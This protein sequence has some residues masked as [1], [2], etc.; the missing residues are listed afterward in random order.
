MKQNLSILE[1][2]DIYF[3]Y[4][5]RVQTKKAHRPD[6]IQRLYFILKGKQSPH[7]RLII[8]GKKQLP[9]YDE[10]PIEFAFV[11]TVSKSFKELIS[12][13][14]EQHYETKTRGERELPAARLLAE[15]KYVLLNDGSNTYLAYQLDRPQKL[16]PPQKQFNLANEGNWVI[17]IK[18]PKIPTE[19]GL[20]PQQKAEFPKELLEQFQNRKFIPL[21]SPDYLGYPGAEL[22]LIGEKSSPEEKWGNTI[23][24]WFISFPHQSMNE[25]LEIEKSSIPTQ[26]LSDVR[27]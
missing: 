2:G 13:L 15:G 26:P 14:Q 11:D 4:R 5:S 19:K 16:G 12:T 25:M 9:S 7:Y 20:S 1:Q 6:D 22:L 27:E 23:K 24:E 21:A 18:N 10:S 17:S 3:F 8:V